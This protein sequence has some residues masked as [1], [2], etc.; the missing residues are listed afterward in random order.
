MISAYYKRL[1]SGDEKEKLKYAKAWTKYEMS[2]SKLYV[3][4]KEIEYDEEDEE[5]NR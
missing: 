2:T 3:D 5:E 1:T 4:P